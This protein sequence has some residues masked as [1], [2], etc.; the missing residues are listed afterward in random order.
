MEY[1]VSSREVANVEPAQPEP[2]MIIFFRGA[3]LSPF[4]TDIWSNWEVQRG[5]RMIS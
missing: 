3:H 1:F 5:R 2:M 4:C